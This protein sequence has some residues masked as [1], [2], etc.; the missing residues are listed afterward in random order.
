MMIICRPKSVP[1]PAYELIHK[2]LKPDYVNMEKNPSYLISDIQESS[3]DHHYDIISGGDYV[4]VKKK[5]A[6]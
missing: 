3:V 4:N 5:E 1:K 2:P 6:N